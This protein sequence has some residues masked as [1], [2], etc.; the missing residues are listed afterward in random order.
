M[1]SPLPLAVAGPARTVLAEHEQYL[2]AQADVDTLSDRGFPVT[3]LSIVGTD[4]YLVETVTGR[5]TTLRA[6]ARGA[7][8]GAGMGLLLGALLTLLTAAGPLAVPIGAAVGAL[9]GSSGDAAGHAL[10]RGRRDFS[11]TQQLTAARYLVLVDTGWADDARL[12]LIRSP[13]PAPV[14][15]SAAPPGRPPTSG[16]P[17]TFTVRMPSAPQARP[18]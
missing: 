4:L 14:P 6:A 5:L 8:S 16:R 7:A 2:N 11:A 18:P 1:T 9:L 17:T 3:R 12:L 15:T 13:E 10:L